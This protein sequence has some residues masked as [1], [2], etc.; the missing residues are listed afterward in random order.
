MDFQLHKYCENNDSKGRLSRPFLLRKQQRLVYNNFMFKK[1]LDNPFFYD[2][3]QKV[4][5][6]IAFGN[7]GIPNCLKNNI[8]ANAK[9]LD[10]GCG[11]AR[12]AKLFPEANYTGVDISQE[13]IKKAKKQFPDKTFMVMDAAEL[14]F[15]NQ[16]FDAVFAVGMFHHL[17]DEKAL[18]AA[19][20]MVRVCKKE[21]VVLII[22]P[23][24][25]HPL[26]LPGRIL[27]GLDRGAHRRSFEQLLKLISQE[28]FVPLNPSL[29]RSFPYRVAAF[30]CKKA[31]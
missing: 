29:P 24:L 17:S 13:Y 28:S 2:L 12:Y 21:G 8:P 19:S 25:A 18:K 26:N 20:E 16:T 14:K 3:S 1:L 4:L 23:V 11:T 5:S 22:D 10:V 15:E 7:T 31:L 6:L 30:R 9:I 27:F